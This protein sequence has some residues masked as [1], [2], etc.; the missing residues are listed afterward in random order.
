[1]QWIKWKWKWKWRWK[2]WRE[3][4]NGFSIWAHCLSVP[5]SAST[6]QFIITHQIHSSSL[7]LLSSAQYL[8]S[9]LRHFS[10]H[11]VTSI[12]NALER[13]WFLFAPS[14]IHK[15]CLFYFMT[16]PDVSPERQGE[17]TEA[18]RDVRKNGWLFGLFCCWLQ[19]CS[20]VSSCRYHS[21][22][23][24][25]SYRHKNLYCWRF[26]L[27]PSERMKCVKIYMR[28]CVCAIRSG[29]SHE[30]LTKLWG[31]KWSKKGEVSNWWG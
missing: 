5:A 31:V 13:R 12:D 11:S 19:F 24:D 2:K 9:Y 21:S 7:R 20:L 10:T 16:L 8:E 3:T 17:K 28:I 27:M 23:Y 29:Y 6:I 22:F 15:S 30:F 4:I 18:R 14:I 1:M 26:F 25:Y